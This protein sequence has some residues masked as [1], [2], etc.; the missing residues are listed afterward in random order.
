VSLAKRSAP[1]PSDAEAI[2]AVTAAIAAAVYAKDASAMARHYAPDANIADLSPPLMRRGF[3]VEATQAWLDGWHGPVES[4]IRDLVITSDGDLALCHGLQYVRAR[5]RDGEKAAWWSR[6]T[7]GLTRTP[8]GWR[9][10][11]EHNSVPFYMDGSFRA[12]ID[13]DP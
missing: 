1:I 7:V 10:F 13:L 6:I 8:E 9:I 3:D 5:T 2:R 12:A 4:E 11:H